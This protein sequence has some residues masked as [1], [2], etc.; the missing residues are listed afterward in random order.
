MPKI[1]KTVVDNA[2][3]A[4]TDVWIWCDELPGFGV[5][6]QPSGRKTY[7]VRYR[8]AGNTQRKQT[9]ARCSDVPPDRARDLARKV[10]AA[11]ADGKDP[12]A[13]R[14]ET[15]I[16]Q[17]TVHD[18]KARYMKEHATPFKKAR[19]ADLDEK[20]WRLHILPAIGDKPVRAITQA[21]ILTLFGSFSSKPATGN[22]ILALLSK[23]F[24]LAEV[25]GWRDKHTNPCHQIKKYNLPERELIL[26]PAQIG[27]L[28]STLTEMVADDSIRP[29][30]AALIRLLMITGCRLREIMHARAEWVDFDRQLLLLPDSKVGQ[31][32]IP[33]SDAA[34]AIIRE[35]Q[36]GEWLIAG[37]GTGGPLQTP[38]KMWSAVKKR[39][40]LPP[41]LRIHDLRHT[42]GSLG[43]M[44]GLSQKQIATMLG[45]RQLST[46]ERY[47]HGHTTDHARAADVIAGVITSNWQ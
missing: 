10:F 32:K 9:I 43:H 19:S 12:M 25:W 28:N 46:T 45:H 33:L 1:T 42:A 16:A 7:V 24:N 8:A 18:M 14:R 13:E 6:V 41:A 20:N 37:R 40:G 23:A 26:T 36:A 11:V 2:K 30:M 34:L 47:L 5:R 29:S 35:V 15:K 4:G 3:P 39:A 17:S 22:Q 21:T 38:H 44:A 31:R 27:K